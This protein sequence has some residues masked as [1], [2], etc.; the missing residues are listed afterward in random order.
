MKNGTRLLLATLSLLLGFVA[1]GCGGSSITISLN[2]SGSQTIN[3]GQTL[4]ITATVLNDSSNQGVTWSLSGVGSLSSQTK[5]SVIYLAPASVSSATTVTVTATSVANTGVTNKLAI[6]VNPTPALT[7]SNSSLPNGTVGVPYTA[8]LGATGGV[9]P[10]TWTVSSGSLPT[11]ATLDANSGVIS[12]IPDA[13]GTSIFTIEVTDSAAPTASAT[14]SLSIAV[15][16]ANS[17]NNARLNGQYAYL[18]RGFDDI[19]GDQFS[20]VGSF[21]ADGNGNIT[22]GLEDING[23]GGYHPV[24]TFTGTYAVRADNRGTMTLKNSLGT[25]NT[26]AIAVGSLNSS[27]IATRAGI[28]EFDDVDGATGKRGSGFVYLQNPKTF[29]LA[30]ITGPYAFQFA[31]QTAET[32]TRLAL[33][34]VFTADGNGNVTN[35]AADTN[36]NGD[37]QR[38]AFTATIATD[39]KTTPFG[40]VSVNPTGI[41]LNYVFYIISANQALAISTNN[42]STAGMLSGDV[43]SQAATAF[44]NA[45]LSSPSVGYQVGSSSVNTGRWTFDSSGS[46]TYSLVWCDT[47]YIYPFPFDGTL[48]YSVAPNGR[49]T[50]SGSS[51]ALGVPGV[52]IFYLV[53]NNKGFMMST[54]SSVSTG[55]LEPQSGAPFSD[56]SLSGNYFFGTVPPGVTQ[57]GV[58]SGM[59]TSSGDGTLHLTAD[60]SE[61]IYYLLSSGHSI[62]LKVNIQTD[63]SGPEQVPSLGPVGFVYMIS[64]KKFVVMLNG[65]AMAMITIFEQ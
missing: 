3:E 19:T 38:Q 57:S 41:P 51:A 21:Q 29:A 13:A 27:N 10:Y 20:M 9:S 42:E 31:G 35:G 53:D 4:T 37:M 2:P 33:T 14:Q 34:G 64:P 15:A 54:D 32:G 48:S 46:A 62:V 30:S 25:S 22:T 65:P 8:T 45:S 52:P 40:R 12:G 58:A 63:G 18:L 26:F 59:G 17:T 28:I 23:P 16:A 5:T 24:V 56:A 1:F 61:P 43:L 50:T 7:I 6:T 36:D 55:F 11:W 60:L 44:S 49:V 47:S 39:G